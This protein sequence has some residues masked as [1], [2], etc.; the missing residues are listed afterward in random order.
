MLGVFATS[1]ADDDAIIS[2]RHIAV[3]V[4]LCAGDA[5][6]VVV[7]CDGLVVGFEWGLREIG[8]AA[9]P[10][11]GARGVPLSAA[12]PG[13][14]LDAHRGLGVRQATVGVGIVEGAEDC[15]VVEPLDALGSP[16][17]GVGVEAGHGRVDGVGGAAVVGGGVAL[18]EVVCLHVA[19][20]AAHE[21]V[22]DFVQI[23]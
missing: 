23:V 21:L 4:L 12:D 13:A 3:P 6:G 8:Q 9:G 20:I 5:V 1:G 14:E 10:L 7:D 16:D 18:V 22:V 15:T 2:A 19:G 17:D 11:N